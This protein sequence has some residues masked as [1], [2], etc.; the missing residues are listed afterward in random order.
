[1]PEQYRQYFL[2]IAPTP[3]IDDRRSV[4]LEEDPEAIFF[5]KSLLYLELNVVIYPRKLMG[6]IGRV[7]TEGQKLI[8]REFHDLCNRIRQIEE[9]S[10][11]KSFQ[12]AKEVSNLKVKGA[13]NREATVKSPARMKSSA[14][15]K[16]PFSVKKSPT[17][18]NLTSV[19]SPGVSSRRDADSPTNINHSVQ[20]SYSPRRRGGRRGKTSKHSG[21]LSTNPQE[22]VIPVN[23]SLLTGGGLSAALS[24]L[25]LVST[26]SSNASNLSQ[27]IGN[28]DIVLETWADNRQRQ[29]HRPGPSIRKRTR[30]PR[31]DDAQWRSTDTTKSPR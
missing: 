3:M 4:V 24:G 11:N 18:V 31:E 17:S 30:R 13:Q 28:D 22:R 20:N 25:E 2:P 10:Q 14:R 16:S 29:S 12:S 26:S 7:T 15:I 19:G 27:G 5:G 9:P 6:Y 23:E 21:G 8:H 1:M